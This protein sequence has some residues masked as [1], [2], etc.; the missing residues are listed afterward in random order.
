MIVLFLVRLDIET[1]I[2]QLLKQFDNSMN[3]ST[4]SANNETETL[5]G[6]IDPTTNIFYAF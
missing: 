3:H 1:E 5:F 6:F 4:V 2:I